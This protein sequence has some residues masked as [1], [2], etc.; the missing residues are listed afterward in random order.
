MD[1]PVERSAMDAYSRAVVSVVELVGPA[2]VAVRSRRRSRRGP[3]D[4]AGSG[5]VLAPDGFVV[6]NSHVVGGATELQVALPDGTELTARPVGDDPATDLAVLRIGAGALPFLPVADAG[7]LRPGQLVVAIGNPLGFESTVSTGVLSATDR[8]LPGAG[9]PLLQLLQHTAPLNPGNSGGPLV[10]SDGRLIGVNTAIIPGGQGLGFAVPAQ[11]LSWVVPRLMAE[12]RVIRGYLGLSGRTEAVRPALIQRFRVGRTAVRV[13]GVEPGSPAARG[14]LERGDLLVAVADAPVD[15]IASLH[16]RMADTP[17]NQR[18]S[19][20]VLR[21][22][23][24]LELDVVPT[25]AADA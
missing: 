13:E 5:F 9:R 11:T 25:R 1:P 16:R 24:R 17:P 6:T 18:V 10:A 21:G 19:V 7:P 20:V 8:T 12:G 3:V 15:S 4:G 2:V 22:S 14:G 23:N